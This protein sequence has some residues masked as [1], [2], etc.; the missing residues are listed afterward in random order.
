MNHRIKMK[1][2][3]AEFEAEGTEESV[4]A[5][6]ESFL[7]ALERR[8]AELPPALSA[9]PRSFDDSLM[10]RIFELRPDDLVTLKTLPKGKA[11]E[12]DSLLLILY[13]YR[14]LRNEERVLATHLLRASAHSGVR[15]YRPAHA[16]AQ[17]EDYLIRS[18]QK[19]GSTYALN[20]RGVAKAEEIAAKIFE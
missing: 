10:N 9:V 6:Y 11:K 8:A 7:A 2:G 3:D 1:L 5:Q 19:K 16:L 17:H 18:G 15:I 14:K 12:A 4:K 13:G 20:N